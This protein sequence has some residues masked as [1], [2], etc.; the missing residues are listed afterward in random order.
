MFRI[1]IV[2]IV[3]CQFRSGCVYGKKSMD[4]EASRRIKTIGL[5]EVPV[6]DHASYIGR[7]L[8]FPRAFTAQSIHTFRS[9]SKDVT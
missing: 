9:H 8:M 4:L 5:P 3:L 2:L 6:P 7:I 1:A